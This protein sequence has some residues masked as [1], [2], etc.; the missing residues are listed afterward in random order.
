M[1][2]TR[3]QH[4]STRYEIAKLLGYPIDLDVELKSFQG[5]GVKRHISQMLYLNIQDMIR[6]KDS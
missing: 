2:M 3:K 6:Y 5:W 4:V 1:R